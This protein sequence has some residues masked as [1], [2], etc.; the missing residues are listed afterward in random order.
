MTTF[1]DFHALHTLAPSNVNRGE[2]GAPK[3]ATFGGVRRQR[4]SSQALKAAQR[5]GFADHLDSSELGVRTKRVVELVARR[6][7]ELDDSL[8][9][10]E[11]Q[12]RAAAAFNLA[13]IKVAAPKV[14]KDEEAKAATAGYLMFL[15]RHQVDRLAQTLVDAGDK[16]L[17]SKAEAQALLDTEHAVDVA[18]FGRMVADDAA[19]NVDAAVQVAHALGVHAATP[20]FDFYTAVDDLQRQD[21]ETG[22]GMI[23]TVEMMSSTL[24]RYATVNVDQLIH[25]LGSVEAAVRAVQAFATTFVETLPT[26]KQNT[27]ASHTLPEL[28]SVAVRDRRPVSYVNAFERPIEASEGEDR[29]L[30]AAQALAGEAV[31]VSDTYGLAPSAA[32]V[33]SVPSL[34]EAVGPLGRSVTR[35]EF[36]AELQRVV[37][38][39]AAAAQVEA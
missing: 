23:G 24:Y 39:S 16:G 30:L 36:V 14:K 22:A 10:A 12:A 6:M 9:E 8:N 28:V 26:G 21:E 32:L 4:V 35:D 5:R 2:D 7:L 37:E 18:L 31:S 34:Q 19:L 3:T 11:A 27:F 38:E 20:D 25:N 13:K 29:R 1:I 15:G 17:G 33:M